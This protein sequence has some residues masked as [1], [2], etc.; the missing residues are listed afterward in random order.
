MA[1][2]GRLNIVL[3]IAAVA[4]LVGSGI[5]LAMATAPH[6]DGDII[7]VNGQEFYW[8]TLQDDFSVVA[9]EANGVQYDGVRISDIV[10]ASGL[11]SPE[12]YDYAI[13][14]ARDGYS[15][16]L[17]WDDLLN[18]YLVVDYEKRAVFPERT[19]SFW[20]DSVGEINPIEG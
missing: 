12:A 19:K 13:V 18:G 3:A 9:F 7:I 14:S 11:E 15:K 20:V 8:E 1:E 16:T 6:G 5:A 17:A 10:N 2:R 4:V